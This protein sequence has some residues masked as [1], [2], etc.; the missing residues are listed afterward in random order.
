MKKTWFLKFYFFFILFSTFKE[1]L[2][3]F[4]KESPVFLYFQFLN[5]FHPPFSMGYILN[6]SQIFIN[7]ISCI[8][9][10]FSIHSRRFLNPFLWKILF[11]L[12]II[13][14]IVGRPYEA[15]QIF[16]YFHHHPKSTLLILAINALIYLPW[17]FFLFYYAF[18]P[19][20]A[21]N[22]QK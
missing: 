17:Y 8:P 10:Y 3:F 13:L 2:I 5:A 19:S 18:R 11:V 7:I 12:K 20:K 9:L 16:S 14:D 15:L 22:I 1:G 6:I 21:I 4:S